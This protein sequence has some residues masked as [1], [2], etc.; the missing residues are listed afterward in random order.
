MEGR[1][2]LSLTNEQFNVLLNATI[3]AG[4]VTQGDVQELY[5]RAERLLMQL[6]KN[7]EVQS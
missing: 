7:S 2:T 5:R 4:H 1:I 6:K 3:L